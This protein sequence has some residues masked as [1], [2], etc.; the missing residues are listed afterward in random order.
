MKFLLAKAKAFYGYSKAFQQG[1]T[2]TH[3]V[4]YT[5][6]EYKSGGIQSEFEFEERIYKPIPNIGKYIDFI[7]L[8][9]KPTKE[10]VKLLIDYVKKYPHIVVRKLKYKWITTG[11]LNR[12][13]PLVKHQ[14]KF[15]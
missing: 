6:G 9:S 3:G 5:E 10:Q 1:I 8:H 11:K 15:Y 13:V 7:D 12:Q 2:F 14:M 4:Y